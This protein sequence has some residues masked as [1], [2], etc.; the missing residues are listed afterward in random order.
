M[1]LSAVGKRIRAVREAKGMTQEELA[2]KA[3]LSP[4]HI[5]VIERSTKVPNLDTFIAIVNALE[6]SADVVLQDV[7]DKSF[8]SQASELSSL[9][10][11]QSPATQKKIYSALRAFLQEK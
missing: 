4:T 11:G 5:G 7:V 10:A 6:V 1:D 2:A 8:E 9:L 3:E